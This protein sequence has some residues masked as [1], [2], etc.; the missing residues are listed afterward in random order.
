MPSLYDFTAGDT[1]SKIRVEFVNAATGRKLVPFSGV[2][3]A[4][5]WV[6]PF[7]GNPTKRTMTVLTGALDGFAEYQFLESELVE[8]DLKV[9]AE[10]ELIADSTVVSQLGITTY[11]V[12][13]KL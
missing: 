12:G 6:K 10:T 2:Y 9:Q 11:H 1:G 8:G 13:P 3:H 5:L 7:G 4:S